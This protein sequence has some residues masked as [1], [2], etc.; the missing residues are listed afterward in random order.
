MFLTRVTLLTRVFFLIFFNS[1]FF[2]KESSLKYLN[3]CDNVLLKQAMETKAIDKLL[4][5]KCL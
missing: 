4:R 5:I 2:I 3:I 1:T